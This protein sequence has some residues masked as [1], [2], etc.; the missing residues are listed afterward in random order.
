MAAPEPGRGQAVRALVVLAGP[1]RPAEQAAKYVMEAV[2]RVR[3]GVDPVHRRAVRWRQLA[4]LAVVQAAL[5]MAAGDLAH[6]V[7]VDEPQ[8]RL[9]GDDD[10]VEDVE[11]LYLQHVLQGADLR[12]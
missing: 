11:F 9:R 1:V 6:L 12:A 4:G 3:Q 7:G 8:A 5:D 10:P 2:P